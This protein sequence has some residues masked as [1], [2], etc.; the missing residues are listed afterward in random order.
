M[1]PGNTRQI[2][3]ENIKALQAQGVSLKIA[4]Q[5]ATGHAKK[6][7]KEAPK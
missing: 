7:K 6:T 3:S 4:A 2:I 5:L 1:K